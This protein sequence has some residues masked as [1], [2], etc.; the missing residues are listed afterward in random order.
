MSYNPAF[1]YPPYNPYNP[2]GYQP[3]PAVPVQQPQPQVQAQPQGFACRA[4]TSREEAVAVQVDFLGPGTIMP[5]LGHG[6]I[7]LKKFNPSTGACD[8]FAFVVQQ[9]EPAAPAAPQVV[10]YATKQDLAALRD[11]L[12]SKKEADT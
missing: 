4:V 11:E 5:D 1:T 10:E 12:I 7:Y 2:Y 9:P 8:F 6:A 3:G